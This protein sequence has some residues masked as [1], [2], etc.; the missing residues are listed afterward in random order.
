MRL[1][2]AAN[3]CNHTGVFSPRQLLFRKKPLG[4]CIKLHRDFDCELL[5][6]KTVKRNPLRVGMFALQGEA[7]LS[8]FPQRRRKMAND[9]E[10]FATC[11]AKSRVKE[12]AR[13]LPRMVFLV[14]EPVDNGSAS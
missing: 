6:A 8:A 10:S 5:T 7:L 12:A 14:R 9:F 11:R 1:A 3:M 2:N 13:I 4:I